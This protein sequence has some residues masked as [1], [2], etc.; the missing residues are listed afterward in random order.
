MKFNQSP[1]NGGGSNLFIHLK[2]GESVKGILRGSN[3]VFYSR[4]AGTKSED[5]QKGD[6]GA[7]FR[8]KL[9]LVVNEDG[10]YKAKIFE[11]GPSVYNAL[12]ELAED[13]NLEETVIKISR[14]GGGLET[15]YTV[16]PMPDK[17]AETQLK[18]LSNVELN[19]LDPQDSKDSDSGSSFD[20]NEEIPF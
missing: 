9:N 7:R 12:K 17:L 4:W 14:K 5:C 2:D 6:D 3:R 15:K 8:F 10:E 18:S 20:T 1:S 16:M 13:Y 11:Q 19:P